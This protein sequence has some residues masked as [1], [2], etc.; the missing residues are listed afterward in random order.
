MNAIFFLQRETDD[1]EDAQ[2]RFVDI[3]NKCEFRKKEKN[4]NKKQNN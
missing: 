4:N 2:L 3:N 1:H